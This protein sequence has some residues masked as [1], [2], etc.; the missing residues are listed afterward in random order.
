MVKEEKSDVKK[1]STRNTFRKLSFFLHNVAII[2]AGIEALSRAGTAKEPEL[3]VFMTGLA[4][5]MASLSSIR[6]LKSFER[7]HSSKIVVGFDYALGTASLG[8]SIFTKDP[9]YIYCSL[10]AYAQ[11]FAEHLYDLSIPLYTRCQQIKSVLNNY[12]KPRPLEQGI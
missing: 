7:E 6:H 10:A 5:S 8:A 9:F 11:G 1:H 12:I 2:P 4:I 3:Y